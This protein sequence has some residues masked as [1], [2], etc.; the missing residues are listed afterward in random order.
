MIVAQLV[1]PVRDQ[2]ERR[3]AAQPP[4]EEAQQVDSGFVGPVHVLD[5]RHGQGSR[6]VDLGLEGREQL[7]PRSP[8]AAELRQLAAGLGPDVE[9]RAE[10]AGSEQ[11]VAGTPQPAGT[12]QLVL[13]LLDQGG[14]P[15]P[16]LAR[17]QDQ[18][19]VALP[20]LGG[21]LGQR[22]QKRLPL[23]QPHGPHSP[24]GSLCGYWPLTRLRGNY[25]VRHREPR[26]HR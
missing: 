26:K 15:D 7:I 2:Q 19:A 25:L 21:V 23:Q 17:H 11:P 14:L 12:L 24:L 1:V 18:P 3:H 10:R 22:L 16:G 5:D 8:L 6:R 9:H 20:G 4:P 13:E